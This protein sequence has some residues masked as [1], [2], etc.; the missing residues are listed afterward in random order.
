MEIEERDP[1]LPMPHA[2]TTIHIKPNML[3]LDEIVGQKPLKDLDHI[4]LVLTHMS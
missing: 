4:Q 1:T 3:R 2:S